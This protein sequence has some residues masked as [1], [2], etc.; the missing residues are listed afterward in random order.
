MEIMAGF[1]PLPLICVNRPETAAAAASTFY[2]V[3]TRESGTISK[4]LSAGIEA[5]TDAAASERR[6]AP[7]I[8]DSY[9]VTALADIIPSSDI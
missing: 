2:G 9:A 5:S 1:P 3:R 8:A 7:M 6:V 4:R